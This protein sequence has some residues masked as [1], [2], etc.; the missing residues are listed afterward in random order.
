MLLTS[1]PSVWKL[2][3]ALVMSVAVVALLY[4]FIPREL[5]SLLVAALFF[6]FIYAF[7]VRRLTI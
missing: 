2:F 6:L 1:T 5:P 3:F 4:Q 7:I